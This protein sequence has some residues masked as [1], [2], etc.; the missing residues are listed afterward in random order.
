[1]IHTHIMRLLTIILSGLFLATVLLLSGQPARAQEKAKTEVVNSF[2]MFWP[3]VAGKTEGDKF[4]SVKLLKEKI[5]GYLIFGPAPKADYQVFLGV[6][7]LLEAEK[8]LS[9]GKQSLSLTTLDKS[10]NE[11]QAAQTTVPLN[12]KDKL[13]KVI[14]LATYLS[15]K[16]SSDQQINSKLEQIISRTNTLL[17]KFSQ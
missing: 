10:V 17:S 13:E 8:L 6:K 12:S 4:Y 3:M 14:S 2:E 16:Y 11:F 7:R 1:M 15:S 5:R 9:E